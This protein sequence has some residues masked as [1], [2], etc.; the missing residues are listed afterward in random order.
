M[1]EVLIIVAMVT[2]IAIGRLWDMQGKPRERKGKR[3]RERPEMPDRETERE[4]AVR[5]RQV[6][7][8]LNY[9]GTTQQK[10]DPS[11]I[12]ERR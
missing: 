1:E 6:Q 5:N 8:M 9:D 11:T 2:G 7:N 12:L 10:I 3:A 4:T